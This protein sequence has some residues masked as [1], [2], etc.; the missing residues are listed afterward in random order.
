MF[1]YVRRYCYE[2]FGTK[3]Q[4]FFRHKLYQSLIDFSNFYDFMRYSNQHSLFWYLYSVQRCSRDVILLPHENLLS[5]D[6]SAI[7]LI[8]HISV[9]EC[10]FYCTIK[11]WWIAAAGKKS[12]LF[13]CCLCVFPLTLICTNIGVA[14]KDLELGLINCLINCIIVQAWS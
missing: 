10:T 4:W 9:T 7:I 3:Y 11:L 12:L 8:V 14:L 1:S 6:I 13:H 2:I 5:K